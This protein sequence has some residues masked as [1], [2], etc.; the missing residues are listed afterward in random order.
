MK[1]IIILVLAIFV[2]TVVCQAGTDNSLHSTIT[3]QIRIPAQLKNQKLNEKV[4]VQFMLING[5]ATVVDVKA[6]NN[7]LKGY[8]LEQFK[9]M[10]FDNITEKQGITYFVDINFKVL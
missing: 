4:N 3:K 10:K 9:T 2:S 6:S 5:K 1:K 7:E 8:I